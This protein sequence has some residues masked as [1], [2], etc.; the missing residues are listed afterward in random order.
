[1]NITTLTTSDHNR[2]VSGLTY[3]YPV[4]SRRAGG[5]SIGINLN[6]NNACNW[7]C[8]YCNV[9]ELK[10]GTPPPLD[11]NLLKYELRSFLENV[12]HGDFMQQHVKPADQQLKDIAFSG[13][14]E[15]TS[16]TDFPDAIVVVKDVL[17]DLK[18]LGKIKIRLITNGSMM[19]KSTV[20]NSIQQLAEYN[21][22]VWFKLDAGTSDRIAE[23]NNVNL[24]VDGHIKRLTLCAEACPTFI[25]TC[26]FAIDNFPP[27]EDEITA[28]IQQISTVK[29][30]IQGIY[31]YGIARQ[32]M[33]PEAFRLSQLPF[34][35]LEK[36]ANRI[37]QNNIKV[38]ISP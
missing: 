7:R 1:M 25:Q 15:P 32:S 4:V 24:S 2:N 35:W 3:I 26:F 6:V 28:Y 27:S 31:I 29:D 10:R 21:G 22:E 11:L 14:G 37:S 9:P 38:H 12:I 5:V 16:A 8:I 23:V 17:D 33:Q 30:L 20:I 13:N 34:E 36:V 19:H 18:L